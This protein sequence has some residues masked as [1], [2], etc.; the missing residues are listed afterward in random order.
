MNTTLHGVPYHTY[1]ANEEILAKNAADLL[2][3][4]YPNHLWAVHVNSEEKGGVMVIKNFSISFRYGYVLHLNKLD[5]EMKK[6]LMAGG[7]I[8]E[9]AKMKRGKWN[10]LNATHIDGVKSS[11]QPY[12]GL[13]V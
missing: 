5:P 13:I 8:L 10:G 11:H 3:K 4:H 2:N 6:V 12:R 9:R 1:G 7:E